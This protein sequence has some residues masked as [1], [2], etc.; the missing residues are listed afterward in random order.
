VEDRDGNDL[1][2]KKGKIMYRI[3]QMSDEGHLQSAAGFILLSLATERIGKMNKELYEIVSEAYMEV[4]NLINQEKYER[5]MAKAG[6]ARAMSLL[7]IYAKIHELVNHFQV[8][9]LELKNRESPMEGVC[10]EVLR[11]I[12]QECENAQSNSM[13]RYNDEAIERIKNLARFVV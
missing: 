1:G 12:L 8:I 7:S 13:G 2:S 4:D 11:Q 6:L 5:A 10:K 9:S 3:M